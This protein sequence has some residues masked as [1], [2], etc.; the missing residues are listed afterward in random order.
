MPKLLV[1]FFSAL[2]VLSFSC[3]VTINAQEAN[4]ETAAEMSYFE[5]S[6]PS[7]K[8]YES[9]KVGVYLPADYHSMK[10]SVPVIYYLSGFGQDERSWEKMGIKDILD[11]L[12]ARKLVLPMIVVSPGSK[13]TG[14]LN[15]YSGENNWEDFIKRDLVIA[16]DKKY[17]TIRT[18]CARGIAGNSMGGIGALAIGFK[19]RNIFGSISAHSAAIHP[20]DP[21]K[22]P[23]WAKNWDGW[24]GRMGKPIDANYW[25]YNNPISIAEM[26]SNSNRTKKTIYFDVG[27]KDHLGFAKT[28][29]L[30]SAR[31][32][33]LRIPHEF[34]LRPGGHGSKFVKDNARFALEFH[35]RV[36]ANRGC[37]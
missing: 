28:N 19:N 36:F 35:G 2:I 37:R 11:D 4:S 3:L 21:A 24:N 8:S 34:N 27:K 17:R 14:W 10:N 30:L 23:G 29:Q 1:S 13:D 22:L 33:E 25:K 20:D 6:A 5:V 7:L 9:I 26:F 12:I 15:W 32:K 16:I 31:L 18:S